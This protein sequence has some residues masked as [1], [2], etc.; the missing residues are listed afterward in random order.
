MA[1]Q[2]SGKGAASGSDAN[3]ALTEDKA[4][5]I[6]ASFRPSWDVDENE[7][8]TVVGPPP[9]DL[10]ENTAPAVTA[11]P[12]V[13]AGGT[14]D[15]R[16]AEPSSEMIEPEQVLDV[17]P[18]PRPAPA[19]PAAGGATLPLG[20]AVTAPA[21]PAP[22]ALPAPAA[23]PAPAAVP[24]P[25]AKPAS[26]A[27]SGNVKSAPVPIASPAA[28]PFRED[29]SPDFVVPKKSKGLVYVVVGL[30]VAAG[31]GLILK[32]TM[33]G[34]D[35]AKTAPAPTQAAQPAPTKE[36]IPPPP[37]PKEEPAST[38]TVANAEPA[39]AEPAKAEPPPPR[40]VAASRPAPPPRAPKPA[41]PKSEPKTAPKPASG[42]IVRDNPF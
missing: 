38:T 19:P 16:D 27:R 14:V 30:G 10:V 26:T 7:V 20:A 39:K 28:D 13:M 42:A 35:T 11:S 17:A 3:P 41:A 37:P 6:A 40:P 34:D 9:A 8:A 22:A 1:M 36:E 31:L 24:A 15:V 2:Q 18:A 4:D 5:E 12:I 29:S 32:F 21:A 33:G 23:K 25:A